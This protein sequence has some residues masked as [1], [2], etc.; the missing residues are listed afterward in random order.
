MKSLYKRTNQGLPDSAS[1]LSQREYCFSA[2]AGTTDKDYN[3]T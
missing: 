3:Q 1:M 2:I